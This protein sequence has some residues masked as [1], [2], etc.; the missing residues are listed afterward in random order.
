MSLRLCQVLCT[1]TSLA[2]LRFETTPDNETV[3]YEGGAVTL[4]CVASGNPPPTRTRWF[5]NNTEITEGVSNDGTNLTLS[6]I[7]PN[8]TGIYQCVAENS[9]ETIAAYTYLL[10]QCELIELSPYAVPPSTF[11]IVCLFVFVTLLTVSLLVNQNCKLI[12]YICKCSC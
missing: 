5:V 3:V 7:E 8:D 9:N 11:V 1:C 6:N 4:E 12:K 2:P 10:V